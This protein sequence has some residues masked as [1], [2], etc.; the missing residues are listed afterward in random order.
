MK[1]HRNARLSVKGRELLVNRVENR[2]WSLTAVP[3][4]FPGPGSVGGN[5][6]DTVRVQRVLE[7]RGATQAGTNPG[8]QQTR[9][10]DASDRGAQPHSVGVYVSGVR[11]GSSTCLR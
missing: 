4:R 3:R 2:G 7:R 11:H 1:L 8:N 5:R 9:A 6:L 10:P